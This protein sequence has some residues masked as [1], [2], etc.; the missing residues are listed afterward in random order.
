MGGLRFLQHAGLLSNQKLSL[1]L[2]L[3]FTLLFNRDPPTEFIISPITFSDWNI[4]LGEA[5][6]I[7]LR[8]TLKNSEFEIH[9]WGDDSHKGSEERHVFGSHTWDDE[10]KTSGKI[11]SR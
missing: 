7:T 11:C 4:L 9:I 8:S 6:K 5:D 1:T 2:G 10:K 3:I